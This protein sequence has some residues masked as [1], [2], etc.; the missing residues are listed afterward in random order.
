MAR[1]WACRKKFLIKPPETGLGLTDEDKPGLTYHAV[2]R[3]VRKGVNGPG[4]KGKD[5]PAPPDQPLQIQLMPVY[6]NGSPMAPDGRDGL[7]Q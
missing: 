1:S 4:S 6:H 7:L 5:R 2:N 3:Y